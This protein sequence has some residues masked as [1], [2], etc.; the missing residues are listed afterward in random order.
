MKDFNCE[1]LGLS[2]VEAVEARVK[3][4]KI[5]GVVAWEQ[6]DV[7]SIQIDNEVARKEVEA[8]ANEE[9]FRLLPQTIDFGLMHK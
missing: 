8:L 4:N 7:L 2:Y 6:N 1:I 5:S 3:F 9:G